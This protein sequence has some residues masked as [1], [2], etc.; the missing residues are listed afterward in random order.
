MAGFGREKTESDRQTDW[1]I[2]RDRDEDRGRETDINTGSSC[3]SDHLRTEF[4]KIVR[5]P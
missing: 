4:E 1:L 5:R 3:K 2:K